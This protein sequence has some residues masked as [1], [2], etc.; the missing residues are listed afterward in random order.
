MASPDLTGL[1]SREAFAGGPIE[2]RCPACKRFR[3]SFVFRVADPDTAAHLG[4]AMICD[5]EF[6]SLM[7]EVWASSPAE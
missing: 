1:S 7:R 4:V 3:P 6:T 2:Y 5:N